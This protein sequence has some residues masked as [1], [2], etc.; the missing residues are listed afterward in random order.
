[1]RRKVAKPSGHYDPMVWQESDLG[2][3]IMAQCV[4]IKKPVMNFFAQCL[5][6]CLFHCA[7]RSE[8]YS[9]KRKKL[10]TQ[11]KALPV[12]KPVQYLY[13]VICLRRS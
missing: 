7:Q 13:V 1:M 11:A 6:A 4:K 3:R 12:G 5:V 9:K 2:H 10:V 8:W